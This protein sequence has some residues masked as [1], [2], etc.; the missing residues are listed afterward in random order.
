MTQ[1]QAG[2]VLKAASGK[3]SGFVKVV[4]ASKGRYG[5]THAATETGE[6]ACGNKPHADATVTDVSA[7]LKDATCR[8]CRLQLGLDDCDEAHGRLQA[9]F[10]VSIT[11]GLRPGELRKLTWDRVDLNR[12]VVHV[13]RSASK[14]SGATKTPQ[15]KRSLELPKRAIAALTMHQARQARERRAADEAWH[16]NNL[17]FCHENGDPYVRPAQLAVQQ[18]DPASGHRPLARPRGTAHRR[19]DHEQQR[20]AD[21][22][23]QRHRGPQVHPRHR[24]Y[25]PPRDR[26]RDPRGSVR[27]G[28]RL[29]R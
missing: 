23:D 5:V 24:N 13:W 1:A 15:S 22:G 10:V 17:V 18:D 6:L 11:L 20:R 19:V 28:R 3:T 7:E 25:L 4:K 29:Q 8:S 27:D 9:L 2:K 14:S 26:V 21:S 16:D 12:G